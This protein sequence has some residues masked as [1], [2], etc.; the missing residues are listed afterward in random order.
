MQAEEQRD[1]AC[2]ERDEIKTKFIEARVACVVRVCG[3]SG[4][5][6]H[7]T[8]LLSH[9]AAQLKAIVKTWRAMID[10]HISD[11]PGGAAASSSANI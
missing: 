11:A 1:A 5:H 8:R 4:V 2:K 9:D 6:Q 7:L 10:V 3:C